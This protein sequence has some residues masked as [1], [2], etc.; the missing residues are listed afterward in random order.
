MAQ[1]SQCQ[2][3][4]CYRAKGLSTL[5]TAGNKHFAYNYVFIN[6]MFAFYMLLLSQYAVHLRYSIDVSKNLVM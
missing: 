4:H 5:D 2:S 3:V 6:G 1:Q